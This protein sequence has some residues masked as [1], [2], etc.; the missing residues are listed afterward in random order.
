MWWAIGIAIWLVLL[1][2][3]LA[4][5]RTSGDADRCIEEQLAQKLEHADERKDRVA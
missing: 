4:L 5:C 2:I 1:V 3:V